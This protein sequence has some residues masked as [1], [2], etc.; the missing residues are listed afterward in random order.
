VFDEIVGPTADSWEMTTE[1]SGF[2]VFSNPSVASIA[3][4]LKEGAGGGG[5]QRIWFVIDSV[6]CI[7]G[8]GKILHVIATDYTGGCTSAIPGEDAYGRIEVEDR[9]KT[10]R[11]FTK[12]DLLN[13]IGSA[14][15]FWP[16]GDGYCIPRWLVDDICAIPECGA[17]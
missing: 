14:T 7:G 12:E 4:I 10:L 8:G 11:P 5:S 3:A 16:R 1:G 15:Y 2:V 9:C 17:S 13:E 6:E